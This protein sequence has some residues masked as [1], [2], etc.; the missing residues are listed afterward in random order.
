MYSLSETHRR[1]ATVLALLALTLLAGTVGY[2]LVEGWPLFDALYMTVITLATVGYG[3]TNPLSPAGRIFTMFLILGGVSLV[4]YA[5]STITS[6]ILEGQLSIVF[7]RRRMEKEVAKLSGHY[8]VC[9]LSHSARVIIDELEKT[10]RAFV[11]V[12][13]DLEKVE[14]LIAEG[15]KVVHGDATE[16][17]IL[18]KAGIMKAAGVFAVLALDQYNAFLALTA[19]G[20][21]PQIRIVSTQKELTVRQQLLRSGADN[22][23][24]PEYIGGL[25][26]VSEMVRPATVGFLDAMMRER[27]S[28]F[29]F[30][31]VAVPEGSS[32]AGL[33]VFR[34]NETEGRAPLLVAVFDNETGHYD[35]NP[36]PNRLIR[37]G[38]RLVMI[39]ESTALLA[40]RKL[41]ETDPKN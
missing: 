41:I 5:F 8:I 26:M 39:G 20:L 4:A 1:L 32:W 6:I 35:I 29:R 31:E 15:F 14:K 25:R 30:D 10:G 19:R 22:V 21:N 27:D 34:L 18:L 11:I 3:E 12:D 17:E 28:V 9:G 38:D 33:P 13:Q 36:D 2:T 40:L 16:E 24:N 23:V 7:K 37:E